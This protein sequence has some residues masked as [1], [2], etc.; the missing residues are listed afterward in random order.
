MIRTL[1]LPQLMN[2]AAWTLMHFLWEGAL[3]AAITS[4][5]L[6]LLSRRSSQ[7]RYAV[8]V[9]ALCTM[10]V[11]PL[12]TFAFYARAGSLSRTLILRFVEWMDPSV[13]SRTVVL[14]MP[15]HS[16]PWTVWVVSLWFAGVLLSSLRIF[17]GWRLTR[18]LL[19]FA[20]DA[21]PTPVKEMFESLKTRMAFARPVSLL[22]SASIDGPAVIGWLRPVVLL[23][24]TAVTG[25]DAAQ[26][27]A[28]L[29][30]ELAHIRRHDFFVN[31]LQQCVESLL[32]YHPA[33][34]WLSRRVR[35]EREHVCDDLAVAVCGDA[36][37]YAKALVELERGRSNVPEMAMAVARGSLKAR[38]RRIFGWAPE[39]RDWREAAMAA[40]FVLTVLVAAAWQTRTVDA[41]AVRTPAA[42]VHASSVLAIAA[43]PM[44]TSPVAVLA[45]ALASLAPRVPVEPAITQNAPANAKAGIQGIVLN[46]S[47]GEPIADAH[48]TVTTARTF[49]AFASATGLITPVE[50]AAVRAARGDMRLAT[51][52][53]SLTTDAQGRFVIDGLDA[54]S[55]SVSVAA[56]G[57]VHQ[58]YGQRS[59]SGT[60][61]TIVLNAGQSIKDIVIRMTPASTVSGLIRNG[62]GKPVV[63]VPVQLLKTSYNASGQRVV[64]VTGATRSDDRGQYRLY[65]VTP[66]RYYLGAGLEPSAAG[67]R[68]GNTAIF[69]RPAANSDPNVIYTLTYYPGVSDRSAASII[70]VLPDTSVNA[71]IVVSQQSRYRVSGRVIDGSTGKPAASVQLSLIYRN[72]AGGSN[73]F[74]G[75]ST[76]NAGTG[77]FELR[78]VAPGSYDVGA[79]IMLMTPVTPIP[80]GGPLSGQGFIASVSARGRTPITVSNAD[81]SGVVVTATPAISLKGKLIVDGI[82]QP[83]DLGKLRVQVRPSTDG[84]AANDA[85]APSLAAVAAD[86]TFHID[87]VSSGEYLFGLSPFPANYYIKEVRY[88][89]K[90]ALNKPMSVVGGASD[91]LEVVLSPKVAQVDGVVLDDKQQ[92]VQGV[93]AVL[94]SDQYRDRPEMFRAVTTDPNGR[95]TIRGIPPGDYK[96]FAWESLEP[97]EYFDP[98]FLKRDEQRGQSM[99]LRESDKT[100]VS[101]KMIPAGT[102]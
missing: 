19:R 2:R 73:S 102:K 29:A 72:L 42:E 22:L 98:D 66:G 3:I 41:Q 81:V 9:G 86:G 101:V 58:D 7:A 53:P 23:P 55:Y 59:P 26:L 54:G 10:I 62:S 40:M 56:G 87:G 79:T 34:W 74:A 44:E 60:G 18:S 51:N 30:H 24:I 71:D 78:N 37:V 32:F 68:A 67:P 48:V 96:I 57:F 47:T 100:T 21:V 77:D 82:S 83:A 90:D 64:E 11:A 15:H 52:I 13:L 95:F 49:A 1:V 89:G 5:L 84:G 20:S 50:D 70:E 65:W 99:K 46:A 16:S 14:P 75:G 12:A 8:A 4:G 61:T 25:L 97:Y 31:V 45:T 69:G 76:Y 28:V 85:L 93:Q 38:I 63:D 80:A 35:I 27:Q 36:T 94:I 6:R 88:G 17:V 91:T 39:D 43:H 33:V 92:P